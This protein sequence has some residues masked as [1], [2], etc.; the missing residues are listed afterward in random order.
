MSVRTLL[1]AILIA[2]LLA[3][4]GVLTWLYA[5]AKTKIDEEARQAANNSHAERIALDYAVGAAVK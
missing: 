2:G 4:I 5:G 1:V 3:S